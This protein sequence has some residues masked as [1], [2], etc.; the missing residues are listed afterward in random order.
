MA[1]K[2]AATGVAG[3][4]TAYL[5]AAPQQGQDRYA[6]VRSAVHAQVGEGRVGERLSYQMPTFFVDGTRLLHV[7]LW[8]EHLAIYP[9]P[10][11]ETDATLAADLEPYRKGKGTLHFP[12]AQEWPAQ[13]VGRIVA[14]HVARLG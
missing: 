2:K 7:G 13:V 10:E 1:A 14:A 11:N 12:Y 9:V 3:E 6:R 4:V 8:E 5:S